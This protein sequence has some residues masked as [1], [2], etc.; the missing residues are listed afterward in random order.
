[1]KLNNLKYKLQPLK[2]FSQLKKI[3]KLLQM[4]EIL[5]NLDLWLPRP[6]SIWPK[7]C[8]NSIWQTIVIGVTNAIFLTK[9]RSSPASISTQQVFVLKL[10]AAFSNTNCWVN[11][12]F[13]NLCKKMRIF[14]WQSWKTRAEPTCL[15]ILPT[16]CETKRRKKLKSRFLKALCFLRIS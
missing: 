11:R 3:L 13:K 10:I 9:P 5:A 15:T 1:M 4:I 6:L 12:R 2:I 7:N 14:C 8:V 16:I